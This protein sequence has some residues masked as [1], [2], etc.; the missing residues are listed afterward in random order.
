MS[1]VF[2]SF[3]DDAFGA[4]ADE[5]VERIQLMS[6]KDATDGDSLSIAPMA[7][8]SPSSTFVTTGT[9]RCL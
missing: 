5:V 4:V 6:N 8:Q 9:I 7:R 3:D 1:G 2:E